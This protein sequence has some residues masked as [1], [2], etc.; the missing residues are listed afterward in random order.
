MLSMR[1]AWSLHFQWEQMEC[2]NQDITA[3]PDKRH[4]NLRVNVNI[5]PFPIF[6]AKVTDISWVLFQWK[7]TNC[8]TLSVRCFFLNHMSKWQEKETQQKWLS[9]IF[10]YANQRVNPWQE[11][12]VESILD[13]YWY[14]KKGKFYLLKFLKT[15]F[16][17]H[18]MHEN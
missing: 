16:F 17:N 12:H 6:S 3:A 5:L 1:Y 4:A 18:C 8:S 14:L 13:M 10:T 15:V 11:N 9:W 7:R 2:I